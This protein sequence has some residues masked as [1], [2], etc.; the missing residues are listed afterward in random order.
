MA[1]PL[2]FLTSNQGKLA[3]AKQHLEPLG[4]DVQQFLIDGKVPAIIEPQADSLGEVAKAKM[5]QAVA[6]LF[7]QEIEAAIMIEDAGL[8]IESLNGFPGV[9]SAYAL[10]SIGCH[11]ILKIL[12]TERVARFEAV[13]MLWDGENTITGKGICSGQISTEMVEG[14][15]F[16]F[17]PI[18]IPDDLEDGTSTGG[19]PF[20]G[21]ELSLKQAFS[22]RRK[23]L[24]DLISKMRI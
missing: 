3:E 22:H 9:Y 13:A 23:A 24:D 12:T 20:G 18:F 15:G 17:D 8:F 6:L 5:Q 16:G 7:S 21:I 2:L 11:G 10:K 14:S 4:F 1:K 19:V